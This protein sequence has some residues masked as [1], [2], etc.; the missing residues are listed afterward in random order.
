MADWKA[1]PLRRRLCSAE[2]LSEAAISFGSVC[3]K[4]SGSRSSA[5]LCSLTFCD[6]RRAWRP[7][8]RCLLDCVRIWLRPLC[9]P[10]AVFL[11]D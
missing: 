2:R 9:V 4:M 6:Q 3:L 8:R 10:E 11:P 1:V 5:S 7:W